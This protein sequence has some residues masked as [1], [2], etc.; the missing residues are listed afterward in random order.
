MLLSRS[1]SEFWGKR[2]NLMIHRFLK[3]GVMRPAKKYYSTSVSIIL[4]FVFSGLL[5]DYTWTVVFYHHSQHECAT[6]SDCDDCFDFKPLKV[7][8]FFL[9]CGLCMLLERPLS[10]Y[11]GFLKSWPTPIV[12]QLV[13]LTGCPVSVV[14][15][16]VESCQTCQCCTLLTFFVVDF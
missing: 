5:H 15:G 8:I 4:A 3:H 10:P 16:Y 12:A 6:C 1:V 9:Y 2:W 13:L 11:L 7:S 14:S